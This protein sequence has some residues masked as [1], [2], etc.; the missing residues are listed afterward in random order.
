ME[1]ISR[2]DISFRLD[3]IKSK[4]FEISKKIEENN[5]E[6]GNRYNF[7][8]TIGIKVDK[9]NNTTNE[10]TEELDKYIKKA[11]EITEKY[12]NM[13]DNLES[14]DE[15]KLLNNMLYLDDIKLKNIF[16]LVND[17]NDLRTR[18]YINLIAGKA[19]ELI[20]QE[21]LRY[22]D[23]KLNKLSKI[24]FIDKITGKSKIKRAM[25]E[26]YNLKRVETINKKYIPENKSLYEV[27]NITNNCGYKSKELEEF[28]SSIVN[29]FKFEEPAVVALVSTQREAK[30]PLF[31][32]REFFN[33]INT[34]NAVLLDKI[35]NKS[36]GN[37]KVSEYQ[38]YN[39]M[40]INDVTT[41]ELF[42]FNDIEEVV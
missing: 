22:I 23:D 25:L 33:K 12:N 7:A 30:I 14:T 26:N 18:E 24:N 8:K 15:Y 42:N 39:D 38:I 1:N 27:I 9:I 40:L 20:R 19:N 35:N 10:V 41:L 16:E 13:E 37:E 3:K 36:K 32:N 28:I 2:K 17:N 31:Y 21:E 6:F 34:E 5:K 29:E 11:D 4:A